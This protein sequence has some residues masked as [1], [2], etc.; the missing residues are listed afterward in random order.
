MFDDLIS[1]DGHQL[2]VSVGC[3]A[4][5]LPEQAEQQLLQEV[6]LTNHASLTAE[7][8][9]AYFHNALR[10]AVAGVCQEQAGADLLSSAGNLAI[11]EAMRAAGNRL[12]FA[13]G[14]E[15]LPPFDADV[16][17]PSLE[18][19][20]LEAMQRT[21]AEQRA[22]GQAEH[23]GRAA[24]M[25]RQFEEIRRSEPTLSPG[26]ILR[27]INPAD[28]GTLLQTLLLA[29][30]KQKATE[31]VWA[32]AGPSL[33]KIDPSKRPATVAVIPLP[34]TLGPLRS[35]QP[36]PGS[37]MLL[38]GARSGVLHV[39]PSEPNAAEAYVDPGIISQLGF[40]RAI[41]WN[42][43]I[44]ACHSEG[45]VVAWNLGEMSE[46]AYALRPADLLGASPRN[47][48]AL[49]EEQLVFSTGNRLIVLARSDDGKMIVTPVPPDAP[50]EIVA[51]LPEEKRLIIVCSNGMVQH[52]DPSTL[53]LV[54]QHRYGNALL[55]ATLMPWLGSRRLLLATDDGAVLGV[56]LDD[57]LVTQ[58]LSPYSGIRALAASAD[59][60]A[61][62]SADRQRIILWNTWD[63]KKLA[64]DVY[65][66]AAA[67]HR[68]ADVDV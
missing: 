62:L 65:I 8:A 45:G 15:M 20:R 7:R 59:I 22:A 63:P 46:P 68:A 52:R 26:E 49:D 57:D 34:T 25:L 51:V 42:N 47:L 58:Y 2:R 64:A 11:I 50:S 38:V 60:I 55:T 27:Q 5:A 41:A 4:R 40:S 31:A 53:E 35:V 3:S 33:V 18:R 21:L 16:Q 39:H 67:R 43:Q 44:W 1:S 37:S 24:E 10:A 6:F 19:Q 29:G 48:Q 12:A 13:C 32:V 54:Q 14:L 9:A 61:G 28:Q 30:G 66:T 56:G 36:I 23:L 17:S